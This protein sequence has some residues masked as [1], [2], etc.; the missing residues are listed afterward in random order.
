[1]CIYAANPISEPVP[2]LVQAPGARRN[3]PQFGGIYGSS[4]LRSDTVVAQNGDG[5]KVYLDS[6]FPQG[7]GGRGRG[8]AT[9]YLATPL[10]AKNA[11]A[12]VRAIAGEGTSGPLVGRAS[13]KWIASCDTS[14]D[15]PGSACNATQNSMFLTGYCF[16]SD[17]NTLECGRLTAA[18]DAYN[19][20]LGDLADLATAPSRCPVGS[21]ARSM[22]IFS[23]RQIAIAGCMNVSNANYDAIAT[24]HVPAYCT[25]PPPSPPSQQE[26]RRGRE[27]INHDYYK[28]CLLA[29]ASNYDPEAKQVGPCVFPTYGCTSAAAVNFNSHATMDDGSCIV[30]VPGCTV[31]ATSYAGVDAATPNYRS[32]FYGSASRGIVAETVYNGPVVINYNPL[33]NVLSSC[34]VAIEGCMD[35]TAVNYDPDAN[36]NSGSWCIPKVPGCMMPAA[37]NSIGFLNPSAS[38]VDGLNAVFSSAVTLHDTT[39]CV[40]TRTGCKEEPY[41]PFGQTAAVAAFNYDESVTVSDESA[42]YFPRTGCLNRAALNYMCASRDAKAICYDASVTVHNAAMCVYAWEEFLSAPPSPPPP[43]SPADV[44]MAAV[45]VYRTVVE[46]QAE[47]SVEDYTPEKMAEGLAAYLQLLCDLAAPEDQ[48]S[49]CPDT[50]TCATSDNTVMGVRAASVIISFATESASPGT[51]DSVEAAAGTLGDSTAALQS[52]LGNA[53][54]ITVLSPPSVSTA[55]E[56]TYKF[57]PPSAPPSPPEFPIDMTVG[58]TIA[59]TFVLVVCVLCTIF[60][61]FRDPR[62]GNKAMVYIVPNAT[63]LG[64]LEGDGMVEPPVDDEP[65]EPALTL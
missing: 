50:C 34:T 4:V 48:Y 8:S 45:T 55:V 58:V 44:E 13:C 53:L 42:C 65:D 11:L 5:A 24:V 6:V 64:E 1:M 9:A 22:G 41:I 7:G 17:T 37:E 38:Q 54:G 39:L 33:A 52:S 51:A 40:V 28:G 15:L 56:V 12:L 3:Q 2:L 35:P 27:E 20:E 19:S 14:I 46:F 49:T 47:G 32:N 23:S 43:S 21:P 29:A 60:A 10:A 63:E 61:W 16:T 57:K 25:D 18:Y 26:T 62:R 59:G 30:A 31:Q 36:V